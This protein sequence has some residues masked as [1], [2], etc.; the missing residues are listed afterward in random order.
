MPLAVA[1]LLR[2]MASLTLIAVPCLVLATPLGWASGAAIDNLGVFSRAAVQPFS[3]TR[4]FGVSEGWCDRAGIA[5]Q[6]GQGGSSR[7]SAR[8]SAL[9]S[10]QH[11]GSGSHALMA[12]TLGKASSERMD[13]IDRVCV[14][15]ALSLA[16]QRVH[17]EWINA[18]TR[19]QY[20]LTLLAGSAGGSRCREFRL[21]ASSTGVTNAGRARA[22]VATGGRWELTG[23]ESLAAN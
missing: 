5:M 13:T 22:C 19:V 21:E 10:E 1:P 4:D 23:T 20:R 17:V 14:G 8:G 9:T 16:G 15:Y 3:A 11:P 7:S 2:R 12:A 6:T 18:N